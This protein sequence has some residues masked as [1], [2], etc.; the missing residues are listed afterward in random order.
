MAATC[1]PHYRIV[2]RNQESADRYGLR[3]HS[4]D[5]STTMTIREEV[6]VQCLK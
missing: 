3:L 1:A 6:N 4:G 2:R 5:V